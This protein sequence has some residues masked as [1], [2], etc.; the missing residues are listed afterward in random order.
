MYDYDVKITKK[1]RPR[2][3]DKKSLEFDFGKDSNNFMRKNHIVIHGECE[4]HKDFVVE[5]G[6]ASKLFSQL[7]VWVESTQVSVIKTR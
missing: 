1:V 5:N 6:F 3:N 4:V 2:A 7:Q